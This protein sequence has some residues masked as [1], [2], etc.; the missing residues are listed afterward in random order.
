M[1]VSNKIE[2]KTTLTR[3]HLEKKSMIVWI[4][5]EDEKDYFYT[6]GEILKLSTNDEIKISLKTK[7]KINVGDR[8]F[9]ALK[10]ED[11]VMVSHAKEVSGS[12]IVISLPG[13][14]SGKERRRSPRKSVSPTQS[15]LVFKFMDSFELRK[16]NLIEYSEHGFCIV[17]TKE[18]LIELLKKRIVEL[19][20][21]SVLKDKV[22][23]SCEIRSLR[24]LKSQ[25]MNHPELYS[26]GFEFLTA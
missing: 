16:T 12:R 6:A 4:K 14:A 2:I 5:S 13:M 10:E 9:L 11:F 21:S 7:L 18:S 3:I 24:I 1:S 8:V 26:V 17:L 25:G 20:E 22:N 19:V 23:F 15:D